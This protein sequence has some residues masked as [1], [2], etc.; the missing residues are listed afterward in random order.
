[1]LKLLRVTS[2]ALPMLAVLS[3]P[4]AAAPA[5]AA[6]KVAVLTFA[7]DD[8]RVRAQVVRSLRSRHYQVA[9]AD[10]D[11]ETV[12]DLRAT[13][14]EM[15]VAAFIEGRIKVHG[16]KTVLTVR[17]RAAPSGTRLGSAVFA[18]GRSQLNRD[19]AR[20]FAPRLR[21]AL[22]RAT[23]RASSHQT[24][25]IADAHMEPIGQ[26]TPQSPHN[27]IAPAADQE[28]E[29]LAPRG[30]SETDDGDDGESAASTDSA[31][32]EIELRHS[33]EAGHGQAVGQ[34][35]DFSLGMHLFTRHFRYLDPVGTLTPYRL[36]W[37]PAPVGTLDWFPSEWVGLTG[38]GQIET[39]A[40]TTDRDGTAFPTSHWSFSGGVRA[41]YLAGPVW[42]SAAAEYGVDAFRIDNADAD[43]P[44]PPV[45]SVRYEFARGEVALQVRPTSYLALQMT[46]GYRHVFHAGEIESV[47]YFPHATV[48]GLDASATLAVRLRRGLELRIGADICR[49]SFEMKSEATDLRMARAAVDDYIGGT[50]S[51]AV[52]VGGRR[53][54]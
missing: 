26:P 7:G 42:L 2:L 36:L 12:V 22:D 45:P 30:S 41:R 38:R 34:S 13:S 37:A 31:G 39:G 46:G 16:W 48:R 14:P 24:R 28:D 3:A 25:V 27:H 54:F 53:G 4:A 33:T 15:N 23:T 43:T 9:L 17:V 20:N 5:R 11:A 40:T 21:R 44:K 10:S 19:I 49:Y 35:L 51:L 32:P 1:M 6:Q 18:G 8:G 52:L 29:P 50:V 47:A